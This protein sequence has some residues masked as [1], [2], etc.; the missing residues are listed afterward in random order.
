MPPLR[1]T[2]QIAQLTAAGLVLARLAQGR[3]R[4]AP[5]GASA[6]GPPPVSV[7]AVV[8]A[9][10]EAGR[11]G[12]CLDGLLAD[13]DLLEVLV[14][15]DG[16]SDA[17][18]AIA[19][20]AGARVV[21]GAPLPAGW[22]GKAWALQQGIE[23]ARGELVLHVDADARPAPGLARALVAAATEHGDD[24]LSAGPAFR[25]ATRADLV[26]HPAFLATLPYRYGVGDA[27]GRRPRP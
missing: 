16:S 1:A 11:I 19:R 17:T 14:V 21:D 27:Q 4:R 26:L 12:A 6:A 5:L 9:R 20:A 3:R 18:A 13:G 24:V 25:C 23:A 22:T 7:S 2:L 10:D 8:P 15:D